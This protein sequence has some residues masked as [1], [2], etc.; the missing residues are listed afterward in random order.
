M[1]TTQSSGSGTL[2]TAEVEKLWSTYDQ[3]KSGTLSR[4][5]LE[6]LCDSLRIKEGVRYTASD[7]GN[8]QILKSQSNHISQPVISFLCIF[9]S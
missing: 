4:A 8:V 7:S 2:T 5:E 6:K 1:H 3:D 9:G